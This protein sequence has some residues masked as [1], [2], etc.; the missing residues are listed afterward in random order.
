VNYFEDDEEEDQGCPEWVLAGYDFDTEDVV[1]LGRDIATGKLVQLSV[2]MMNRHGYV[3][4]STGSGK[5][6]TIRGIIEFLSMRG[7]PV[8][9]SDAKGDLSGM[10]RPGKLTGKY[11]DRARQLAQIDHPDEWW[12]PTDLPVDFF[13]LGG[14]GTGIPVRIPA[15]TF[16]YKSM[17]KIIGLTPS[18]T[19]AFASAFLA[20][21]NVSSGG[22][23][24]LEDLRAFVR[25]CFQDPDA[26]LSEAVGNRVINR[27]NIFEAENPGLFGG[28][29][30]DVMDFVQTVDGWGRVSVIDSSVL[31]DTPD[32]LTTFLMWVLDKLSK[33]LPEVGDTGIPKCVVF[34][35]EAHL[36]FD[37]APKEFIADLVRKIKTLRSKGVGVFFISQSASDIHPKV[38]AQCANRIQHGLR[39]NTWDELRAVSR[40]AK[41]F[42]LSAT[43]K[44]EERLT[45]MRTGDA[46]VCVVDDT[47]APTP[48]S[49]CRMYVPRTSVEVLS[50]EE[51]HDHVA[52]SE[53]SAK[54]RDMEAEHAARKRKSGS[55]P[56]AVITQSPTA[57][58]KAVESAV[59]GIR[60]L[61]AI[62]GQISRK[63]GSAGRADGGDATTD[64]LGMDAEDIRA[65]KAHIYGPDTEPED[66]PWD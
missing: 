62:M 11:L 55:V 48:V 9:L 59:D 25:G 56:A 15:G 14:N 2:P 22:M 52:Q 30:F 21:R 7:V 13:A 18:Q 16:D 10:A 40:T 5:T 33:Y 27:I 23:E 41:T 50:D 61:G 46:L 32:V 44:V 31:S 53:L 45:S 66:D 63:T 36:L 17:A 8:I 37:G 1:P 6:M 42:P 64:A 26:G 47:G 35:D 20:S 4:G 24:T 12:E 60:G 65:A 38:L 54:Y 58:V 39:A 57:A 49:V 29:E 34:L 51:L 28:P 3:A 19:N 43:Y